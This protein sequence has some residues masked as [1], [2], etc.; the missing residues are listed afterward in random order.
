LSSRYSIDHVI[1]NAQN[2]QISLKSAIFGLL[3]LKPYRH[4]THNF[5]FLWMITCCIFSANVYSSKTEKTF[6]SAFFREL[7]LKFFAYFTEEH[8]RLCDEGKGRKRPKKLERC[9]CNL[10]KENQN[11]FYQFFQR[12]SLMNYQHIQ[13]DFQLCFK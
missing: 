11:S 7:F 9:W 10:K 6:L 12:Y 13:M 8:S 1:F 3:N 5:Y 2:F 4:E